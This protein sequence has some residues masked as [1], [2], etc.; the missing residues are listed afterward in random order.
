MDRN[1]Y[2]IDD[3]LS[4]VKKR[5]EQAEAP[6]TE[7]AAETEETVEANEVPEAQEIPEAQ[8]VVQAE[9]PAEEA[10]E[11]IEA[12]EPVEPKEAVEEEAPA[13]AEEPEMVNLMELAEAEDGEPELNI[14]EEGEQNAP[15]PAAPV[16]RHE[17]TKTKK[18]LTAVIIALVVLI[19]GAAAV[20]AVTANGWLNE[21]MNNSKDDSG[22]TATTT[23]WQG[24][25]KLVENFDPI[26]ETE[27]TEL[28]SLEDMIKT[29]YYNGSPCSSTHVLN[30]LLIGEDTRG[31]K[32]LDEGTRADSAIIVSVNVDTG[33][34][35]LTS[36]LRDSWAYWETEKGNEETGQF[37]KIN[38]A[39][40]LGDVKVYKRTIEQLYKIKLDGHAIVN[41]DSFE[42]IVNALGG[43]TL[44]LTE[45][46]INEINNHPGTY[47]NVKIEKKFEGKKGKQKVNGKQAL[48]YCRIRHID[49]D[50]A[51][52]D[53]QKTCLIK[54]FEQTK[55]AS[56][57][58][59]IKVIKQLIP[60]VKT[61]FGKNDIIKMATYAISEGWLDYDVETCNIPEMNLKGGTFRP[62]FG[63]QWIWRA[64]F[65]ADAYMMQKRI[66]GK[67]CITLAHVRVD[68]KT[69]RQAGFFA[70]GARATTD[71]YINDN[72][73]E[74]STLPPT[75]EEDEQ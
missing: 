69:I 22:T 32:I 4:E 49:S 7:P 5:K 25:K 67:S 48:A 58:K 44:E 43:V 40:S 72:Y 2:N 29:W 31:K 1:D 53:R 28:S 62:D 47:G 74:E 66:Y 65:P 20:F 73:G 11:E 19:L 50:G 57:A 71:T 30:V 9:E 46:E 33:K 12:E 54:I 36:I 41:F 26:Q 45:A 39:M 70:D 23:Q 75:T 63:G 27:A 34:V 6:E 68:T 10:A 56:T 13:E 59:L 60:Y 51:R 37:G 38:G 3:I 52:A 21:I 14:S 8:E 17:K 15:V 61:S 64:D 55:G 16:R 18:A 42:Y 35:T 24:M